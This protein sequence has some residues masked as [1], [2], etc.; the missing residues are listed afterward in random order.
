MLLFTAWL[1]TT[2]NNQEDARNGRNLGRPI[3]AGDSKWRPRL[4]FTATP[5]IVTKLYPWAYDHRITD[6]KPPKNVVKY[7][8]K[9][10]KTKGW[11]PI[12]TTEN[13]SIFLKLSMYAQL[14]SFLYGLYVTL[15]PSPPDTWISRSPTPLFFWFLDWLCYCCISV[16]KMSV[17]R[18]EPGIWFPQS[19]YCL[20]SLPCLSG[21]WHH[22]VKRG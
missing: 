2:L 22:A 6:W 20:V 4:L 10:A 5:W 9:A 14:L 16:W 19:T 17:N 11:Y 21:T 18:R 3:T 13:P 7:H 15:P 1:F 12:W 8:E